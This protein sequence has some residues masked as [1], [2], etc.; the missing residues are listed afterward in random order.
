MPGNGS[1][2]AYNEPMSIY[3]SCPQLC[4]DAYRIRLIEPD[5]A[6]DLLA[7]YGDRLALP[8]FNSDNCHGANFY[9]R[10][11]HDV[12]AS[13]AAWLDEYARRG[14]VR[15][16]VESLATGT[17]IGTLEM[18]RREADD[19]YD[20]CGILRVDLAVDYEREDVIRDLLDLVS[21]PFMTLFGCAR[22]ATKAP[23]YAVERRAALAGAGYTARRQPLIGHDGTH[24]YD[25]WVMERA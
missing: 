1:L 5:D 18:F 2:R 21:A 10:D 20:G 16:A 17:V 9:C 22:I 23:L 7:V 24:Y 4:D 8:F 6:D 19:Y 14:F 13:I 12:R 3:D 25:Y 11:V 15:F